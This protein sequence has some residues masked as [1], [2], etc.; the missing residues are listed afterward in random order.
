MTSRSLRPIS[1][2]QP[3]DREELELIFERGYALPSRQALANAWGVDTLDARTADLVEDAMEEEELALQKI[4][5][6]GGT[7]RLALDMIVMLGGRARG[8]Q[9]RKELLLR[10]QGDCSEAISALIARHVLIVLSP[11]S[12]AEIDV[13]Q[14]VEKQYFLKHELAISAAMCRELDGAQDM[15]GK[16]AEW[17]DE[18]RSERVEL[19]QSLELNLLHLMARLARYPLKLNKSGV[20][21]RRVA[22]KLIEGIVRPAEA[23]LPEPWLELDP[24]GQDYLAFLLGM[25][26]QLDFTQ[27][28][29]DTVS[30]LPDGVRDF[31]ELPREVRQH[32][33]LDAVQKLRGWN[34]WVSSQADSPGL[35]ENIVELQLSLLVENGAD[36]IGARGYLISV[37]RR[38]RLS[39]WVTL[40]SFV[41]LCKQLDR[42]YLPRIVERFS[43]HEASEDEV[44][45]Y[46]CAFVE[47]ALFWT[48]LVKLGRGELG[49]RLMALSEQ[50]KA[51]FGQLEEQDDSATE[52][53]AQKGSLVVQPNYEIMV[54]LDAV[55]TP[56]LSF[57]YE[58]SERIAL[59]NRVAT[60]RLDAASLQRGYS[61]GRTAEEVVEE[62][63]AASIAPLA[64]SVEFQ[65]QDWERV[66]SR[67]V[68][69]AR[70]IL[71]RH[72][73][74]DRLDDVISELRYATRDAP[75]TMERIA[76]GSVFLGVDAFD[77][78]LQKVLARHQ[79]VVIDYLG[80]I[81]PLLEVEGPLQLAFDPLLCD[82]ITQREL[83]RIATPIKDASTPKRRVVELQ[84]HGLLERWPSSSPEATV[85]QAIDFLDARIA[86]GL[87]PDQILR[88]RN[89]FGLEDRLEVRYNLVMLELDEGLADLIF[90]SRSLVEDLF[91]KRYSPTAI[92]VDAEQA[93]ELLEKLAEI[94]VVID[95]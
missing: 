9:L 37:I 80:E 58:I 30:P 89:L 33:L 63:N 12:H 28:R 54:F 90:S 43:R 31:F 4:E 95:E 34:E 13:E 3:I 5:N 76:A 61:R 60:F 17:S 81:P 72:E 79:Q 23:H 38:A 45:R 75:I 56:T 25:S 74:P 70:G 29:H 15:T 39:G 42:D 41:T 59:A 47:H 18:I 84:K 26:A 52:P 78:R 27:I 1:S 40:K 69:W 22:A 66:W 8:E 65:I 36:L 68:L 20:P 51:V 73:D 49:E 92:A 35:D 87:P 94:G 71:L 44:E 46:V 14:V 6:L 53:R 55:T 11:S 86:S 21:N 82:M 85:K 48:G 57:L 62:L 7:E 19:Q 67:L 77:D 64:S 83:E 91:I 2:L 93:E 32:R 10:G 88:L 24:T 16:L 50:G